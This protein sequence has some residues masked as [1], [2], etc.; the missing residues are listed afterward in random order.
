MTMKWSVYPMAFKSRWLTKVVGLS[1]GSV[2]RILYTWWEPFVLF[3]HGSTPKPHTDFRLLRY[4][5]T[6]PVQVFLHFSYRKIC[7]FAF[8]SVCIEK[9]NHTT[10][11]CVKNTHGLINHIIGKKLWSIQELRK[12]TIIGENRQQKNKQLLEI[13][14]KL[15]QNNKI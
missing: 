15:P 10:K 5:M 8:H 11:M 3:L 7:S 9:S 14:Q 6:A 4:F 2:R 12:H 13:R 1:W